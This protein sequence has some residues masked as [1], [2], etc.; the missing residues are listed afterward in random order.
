MPRRVEKRP[1]TKLPKKYP[2]A[3]RAEVNPHLGRVQMENLGA[4]IW[5]AAEIGKK[6][7][8]REGRGQAIA[9]EPPR[10]QKLGIFADLVD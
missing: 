4:D 6:R 10:G 1:E 5:R 7:A 8:R 3:G 2:N 9:P